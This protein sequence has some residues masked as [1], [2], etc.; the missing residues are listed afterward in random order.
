[1]AL[2][3]YDQTQDSN[4]H[5][6]NLERGDFEPF[7]NDP[8]NDFQPLWSPDGEEI[9]FTSARSGKFALWIKSVNRGGDAVL[10]WESDRIIWP[11][12]WSPD[13]NRIALGLDHTET[14]EDIWTYFLDGDSVTATLAE[15]YDEWSPAFSPDGR[16]FAYS[17]NES[18]QDE[19]FVMPLTG[20]GRT[21][22]ISRSGGRE[23]FWTDDGL[24][25]R[26][27]SEGVASDRSGGQLTTAMFADV[28]DGDPCNAEPVALFDGLEPQHWVVSPDGEFF[29]GLQP[30]EAPRLDL[31]Q[32]FF[33]LL[34][35]R[36][37]N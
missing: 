34:N 6:Y 12:S 27:S 22:K 28:R 1:L 5:L 8:S 32:N 24:F 25:Y 36:V 13:G 4:I 30:R 23:V 21:C 16:W 2:A 9:V 35:E 29:V 31:V 26:G 20:D 14:G 3:L 10:L 7:A 37:P 33:G 15:S 17:S 19:V 11:L 18:G